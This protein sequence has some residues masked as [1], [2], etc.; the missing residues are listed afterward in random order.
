MTDTTASGAADA[1]T[2]PPA[3]TAPAGPAQGAPPAVPAPPP[4]GPAA[5]AAGQQQ[6]AA[7]EQPKPT[8]PEGKTFTQ[9]DLDKILTDRLAR[10]EK[11]FN[12][13][14]AKFFGGDTGE[15]DGQQ[16]PEDVLAQATAMIEQERQR[17]NTAWAHSCAQA[18]QIKPERIGV[19]IGQVD[20]KAALADV[21]ATDTTAVNAAIKKAVEAKAAEFPEW[22][23]TAAPASS[24]ANPNGAPGVP[25]I[26]ARI[27]AATKAGNHREAIALKRQ[28]QRQQS[29]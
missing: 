19:L 26:D 24:T 5:P 17:A 28:K 18:A 14:L 11:S 8:E 20:L 27:A 15:G 7:G 16:K 29:G 4:A 6:P 13:R 22:K 2:T 23:A 21:D 10:Q 12:D 25:D 1:P 3:Q 9:A